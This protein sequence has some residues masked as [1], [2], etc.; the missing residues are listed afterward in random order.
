MVYSKLNKS[1]EEF[2]ISEDN[3]NMGIPKPRS[4]TFSKKTST[5]PKMRPIGGLIC[6]YGIIFTD[7]SM[8]FMDGYE[9]CSR[10]NS[11]LDQF[12]LT[13]Y[14]ERPRIL[15]LTGHVESEYQR[16]AIMSGME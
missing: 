14:S 2:D 6:N 13:D 11:I 7:C 8:P 1:E 3:F 15:A 16:K 9:C 4:S 12:G 10:M 5:R